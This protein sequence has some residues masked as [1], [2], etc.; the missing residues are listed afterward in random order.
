MRSQP[1]KEPGS[2]EMAI[3]RDGE[4][5]P[6]RAAAEGDTPSGFPYNVPPPPPGGFAVREGGT[7]AWGLEA[8][9]ISDYPLIVER[10]LGRLWFVMYSLGEQQ[11]DIVRLREATRQGLVRLATA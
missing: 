2:D 6:Q 5:G 11:Q 9:H 10:L 7:M 4:L 1:R 3:E 8:G